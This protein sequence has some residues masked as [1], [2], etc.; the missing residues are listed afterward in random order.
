MNEIQKSCQ[1]PELP[2]NRCIC[3]HALLN[4][5]K[6]S[7][8][9][10]QYLI[11]QLSY[12]SLDD[13]QTNFHPK[14]QRNFNNVY[15]LRSSSFTREAE[16]PRTRLLSLYLV[17]ILFHLRWMDDVKTW[18]VLLEVLTQGGILFGIFTRFVWWSYLKIYTV[19]GQY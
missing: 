8:I 18:E 7:S 19:D 17:I 5:A 16:A 11:L 1:T 4:P 14:G 2:R 12:L 3:W 6:P 10:V 15:L 9:V 13:I